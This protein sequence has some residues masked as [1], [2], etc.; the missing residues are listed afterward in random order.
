MTE[1]NGANGIRVPVA[2]RSAARLDAVRI[3]KTAEVVASALRSQIVRGE[4]AAGD[5]LPLEPELIAMFNIS[6]P[7]MR[8][9]FRILES[10]RLIVIRRGS[11]GGAQVLAPDIASAS[12]QVG[13]VMQFRGVTVDAVYHARALMESSAISALSA[14]PS[15]EVLEALQANLDEAKSIIDSED[16]QALHHVSRRFHSMLVEASGNGALAIFNDMICDIVDRGG[17]VYERTRS[18]EARLEAQRVAYKSHLKIYR[19]LADGDLG[20]A[21]GLWRRHVSAVA[22]NLAAANPAG[23]TVLDL[24]S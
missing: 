13:L 21:D 6:R 11:R 1:A 4:L 9:A 5:F 15:A 23:S 7:T 22:D 19:L 3:P 12:E 16:D 18:S 20:G 10:E 14:P 24:L 8:E 2:A 17:A